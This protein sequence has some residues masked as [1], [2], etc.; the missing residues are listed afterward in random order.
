MSRIARR[1]TIRRI[2][3]ER[4]VHSQEAVQAELARLGID[5]TQATISRDLRA[6]GAVKGPG[7]YMVASTFGE[8]PPAESAALLEQHVTAV[9]P[10]ACMV[11]LRT[12]PGGAQ[13]VALELDR[14]P[15]AHVVGTVAGDDTVLVAV[16]NA[17]SVKAVCRSLRLMARLGTRDGGGA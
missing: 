13:V 5:A 15:P 9:T 10:A 12:T 11:V 4:P 16:A 8:P 1:E 6:I 14:F 17:S 2:V 3:A 7:G